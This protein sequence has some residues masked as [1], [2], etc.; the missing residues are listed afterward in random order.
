MPIA[1]QEKIPHSLR[2]FPVCVSYVKSQ[3][4]FA[5]FPFSRLAGP[6][7]GRLLRSAHNIFLSD[8]IRE[9]IFQSVTMD[10][11][12]ANTIILS[13]ESNILTRFTAQPSLTINA[14]KRLGTGLTAMRCSILYLLT[15]ESRRKNTKVADGQ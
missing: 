13:R 6:A 3:H 9:Q 14:G 4:S 11:Y 5:G 7:F 2:F 15:R 12:S 1:R 8:S 10:L